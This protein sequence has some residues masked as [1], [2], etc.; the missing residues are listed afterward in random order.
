[1][2][3]HAKLLLLH[4]RARV[5]VCVV[6]GEMPM[7]RSGSYITLSYCPRRDDA[8]AV[9]AQRLAVKHHLPYRSSAS[10]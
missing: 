4:A 7:L 5:C 2:Y 6:H 9:A 8:V 10:C 1:M 3:V